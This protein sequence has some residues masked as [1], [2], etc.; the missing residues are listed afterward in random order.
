LIERGYGVL[1]RRWVLPDPAQVDAVDL[2][3]NRSVV[4]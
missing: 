3:D 2:R 1:N 4:I